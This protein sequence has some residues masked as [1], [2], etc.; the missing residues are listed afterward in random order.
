MY[1]NWKV[2]G[3]GVNTWT[4]LVTAAAG[5]EVCLLDFHAM[6]WGIT[7]ARVLFAIFSSTPPAELAVPANV[8]ALAQ[9]TTGSTSYSYR[10]SALNASG[11]SLASSLE[12]VSNGNASLDATNYNRITWNGV[13]GATKYRVYG[14][15]AANLVLLGET[16]DVA[17]DDK[18]GG[19][20][21]GAKTVPNINTTAASA[22]IMEFNLYPEHLEDPN[23][24]YFIG[25]AKKLFLR[26]GEA[27]KVASSST[28]VDILVS[29]NDSAI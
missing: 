23:M 29:G 10:V 18:G 9:G 21:A 15:D 24:P 19:S 27:L 11:E 13:A 2:S 5:R 20:I 14:N 3:P 4:E 1:K 25:M 26:D 7:N 28:D 22:R 6:N 8:N 17:F 16:T 12:S